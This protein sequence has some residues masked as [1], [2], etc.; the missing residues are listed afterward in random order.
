MAEKHISPKV[1]VVIPVYN[2]QSSLHKTLDSIFNQSMHDFEV[3]MINDGSSDSSFDILQEYRMK[4]DNAVLINLE[5]NEGVSQ[6]RNCGIR[7]A[8]G[9]YISF[10]D[11]DDVV[12]CHFLEIMYQTAKET[13]SEIASCNFF[14]CYPQKG[15]TKILRRKNRFFVRDGIYDS[16]RLLRSLLKDTKT[17]FFVWNKIYKRDILL[18]HGIYF[19]SRCFEDIL[20]TAKAFYYSKKICVLDCPLYFYFKTNSSLTHCMDIS[21]LKSYLKALCD[22]RAF[23]EQVDEYTVY[24]RNFEY[25]CLRF[26][27]SCFYRVPC[28]CKKFSYG[29]S[30]WSILG[31][32]FNYICLL[33]KSG[34]QKLQT[35]KLSVYEEKLIL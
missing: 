28:M 27:L 1:S 20:F 23:L 24:K 26:F 33:T 10:V 13:G 9:E 30:S 11:A 2:A 17:R 7:V 4:Y 16:S 25:L 21:Q 29:Y 34:K 35:Q 18:E 22:L 12:D 31:W 5:R 3:I 8:K 19:D 15:G 14:Y 6:A 32:I